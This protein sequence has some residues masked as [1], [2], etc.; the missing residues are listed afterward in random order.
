VLTPVPTSAPFPIVISRDLEVGPNRFVLGLVDQTD[1]SQ[2]LGA[3]LTLRFFLLTG[4]EQALKAE[5]KPEPLLITKSYTHTHEDGTVETHEAGETGAY[6]A[7]V[8]FDTAGDWGVEITGTEAD[9]NALEAVTST[10]NVL[11]ES[12]GLDPG[13]AAPQSVQRVLADVAGIAEIDSSLDPIA[14]MHDKTIAAAVT[15]GKPTLIVFATP[16][17]CTSQICGPTKDIV[18][19]LYAAYGDRA[20]FVHV[21]P[22]DLAKA[23][24]GEALEALP[25]LSEEWGLNSEPWVFVVDAQGIIAAKFDG[26]ASYEEMEAALSAVLSG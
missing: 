3:D 7:P 20:N 19:D 12:A 16:A 2:I 18:D 4:V 25:L 5:V 17:F 23:R 15:S 26:I 8:T 11:A 13:D 1:E 6:V 14:E 24:S 10:F 9:G 21:E 22:Y